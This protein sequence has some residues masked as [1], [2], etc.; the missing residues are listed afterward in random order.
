MRIFHTI[1]EQE[2]YLAGY[3]GKD[4]PPMLTP[5]QRRAFNLGVGDDDGRAFDQFERDDEPKEYR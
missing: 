2:A 1:E 5:D 3:D 4:E